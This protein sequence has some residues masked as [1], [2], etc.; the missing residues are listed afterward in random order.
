MNEK[1]PNNQRMEWIE[2]LNQVDQ[3][4]GSLT[5]LYKQAMSMVCGPNWS[6]TW[7][8]DVRKGRLPLE[9]ASAASGLA[10]ALHQV[11]LQIRA[12]NLIR[13]LLGV[14]RAMNE[15]KKK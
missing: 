13:D 15:G 6:R 4:T 11:E 8:G 14:P 9:S 3:A 7:R 2:L 1:E 12:T 10:T 5:L